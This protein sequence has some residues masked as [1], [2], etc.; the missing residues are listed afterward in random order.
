VRVCACLCMRERL[1]LFACLHPL[2]GGLMTF[3][4]LPRYRRAHRPAQRYTSPSVGCW[5]TRGDPEGQCGRGQ[6]QE[7]EVRRLLDK[8]PRGSTPILTLAQIGGGALS[9]RH[10]LVALLFFQTLASMQLISEFFAQRQ[11]P[12]LNVCPCTFVHLSCLCATS[13]CSLSAPP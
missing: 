10:S 9:F 11:P 6:A 12:K 7:D 4:P 3:P 5:V 13:F 2:V 1:L 8:V